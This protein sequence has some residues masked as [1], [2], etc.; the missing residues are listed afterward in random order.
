VA[1][2]PTA[3]QRFEASEFRGRTLEEAAFVTYYL[4]KR[5]MFGDLKIEVYDAEGKLLSS[6]PGGKR[7]GI[8]RYAWPMRMK[9]PKVP[10]GTNLVPNPYSFFGP[11]VPEGE[12]TVKLVK[13]KETYTT[14]LTLAP[15][16][17]STHSAEDRALQQKTVRELYGMLESLTFVT[18]AV[19]DAREQVRARGAKL[20]KTD[21]L[22]K[23]LASLGER[24]DKIHQGLTATREG[25]FTGEEQLRE[26]LGVLYGAVNGFDGRP[27]E[28]Q[29]TYQQTLAQRLDTARRDFETLMTKDAAGLEPELKAKSLDPIKPMS[30]DEWAKK[31]ER[32]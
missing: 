17:R 6:E 26:K 10:P 25:Q 7:R 15:D 12:Y 14:K 1:T 19:V 22:G 27:T 2:L 31:Q 29:L 9:P 5:H 16:P 21:A 24:L 30:H 28:S 3:E 8:N 20:A 11:R 23:K 32:G 13:D 4:K 18:D